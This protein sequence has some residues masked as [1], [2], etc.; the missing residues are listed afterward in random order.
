MAAD[1]AVSVAAGTSTHPAGTGASLGVAPTT[2][3]TTTT[4]TGTAPRAPACPRSAVIGIA[5]MVPLVAVVTATAVG[6]RPVRA[7]LLAAVLAAFTVAAG[8]DAVTGR[9]PDAVLLVA[10]LPTVSLVVAETVGARAAGVPIVSGLH[11][12]V[13]GLVALAGPVLALHLVAP[14][15][16]GFGDVKAAATIGAALGAVAPICAPLA[17]AI[18]AVVALLTARAVGRH[19]VPLGPSFVVGAVVA[20]VAARA[21]GLLST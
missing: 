19:H 2:G 16:M 15:W 8:I 6:D 20:V 11:G 9:L 18:T 5:G 14:G 21:L 12:P 17:G 1:T 10:A 7:V 4:G 3:P 13:T